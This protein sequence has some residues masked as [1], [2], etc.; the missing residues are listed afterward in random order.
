M[1]AP[2]RLV[3]F[4]ISG[5]GEPVRF[6]LAYCGEKFIDERISMEEFKQRKDSTCNRF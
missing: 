6:M 3:Y 1:T 2:T 5:L 4:N